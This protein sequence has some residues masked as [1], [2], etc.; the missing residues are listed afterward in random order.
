[1]GHPTPLS[2]GLRGSVGLPNAGVLTESIQLPASGLGYRRYRPRAASYYGIP[3]L[4]RAIS[5][6]AATVAQQRPHGADLVVGDLS[7][8]RGGKIPRHNSHRSGR[9]VD[10]LYYLVTPHGVP[11]ENPGFFPLDADGFVKFP[12]ER[13]AR[14]DVERQWLLFRALLLDPEIDVQYMFMSRELEALVV[15]YA[16]ARETDLALVWHAQLVMLQPA[17]SLPHADHVHVRI[18]CRPEEAVEGCAGGG[19]HWPWL[20]PLPQL[21]EPLASLWADI[22]STDPF[23]LGPLEAQASKMHE[24]DARAGETTD[25]AQQFL[26]QTQE[27]EVPAGGS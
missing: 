13:Y 21:S 24:M 3:R 4:V 12:D 19:P 1:M 26:Q 8:R 15:Q 10:F 16:L 25:A 18:A 9:D 14:L 23:S 20:T 17:D 27:P 22:G 11:F 6:A 7:G 2:P 5:R